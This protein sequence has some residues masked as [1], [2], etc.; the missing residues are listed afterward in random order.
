MYKSSSSRNGWAIL[1]SLLSVLSA[2]CYKS[3][4]VEHDTKLNKYETRIS[5]LE[6][7][8][9]RVDADLITL[10]RQYWS[11]KLCQ[12]ERDKVSSFMAEVQKGSEDVCT[13]MLFEKALP[14]MS[15]QPVGIV[16]LDPVQK[17]SSLHPAREAYLRDTLLNEQQLHLSTRV[18]V[19]VQPRSEQSSQE[20][21]RTVRELTLKIQNDFLPARFRSIVLDPHLLP[22]NLRD[23]QTL[24]KL[25]GGSQFTRLSV[26]LPGEPTA[27]QPRIRIWI[28][29]TDC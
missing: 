21:L 24:Q 8:L 26:S 10:Q 28:F 22:C 7:K 6:G 19:L 3:Q 4:V 23:E 9:R 12:K 1:A 29:R 14:F 2:Q 20:D 15:S 5:T 13:P 18:L 16:Y 25:Y 17:L 11:E 27:K